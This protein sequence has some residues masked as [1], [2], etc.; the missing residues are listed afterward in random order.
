MRAGIESSQLL[1]KAMG[2]LQSQGT[3]STETLIE[4]TE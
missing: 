1:G 4:L 2:E 3:L